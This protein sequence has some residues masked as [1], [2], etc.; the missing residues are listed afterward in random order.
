MLPSPLLLAVGTADTALTSCGRRGPQGRGGGAEGDGELQW[1]S[2]V[3]TTLTNPISPTQLVPSFIAL[4]G[5]LNQLFHHKHDGN[6]IK[7]MWGEPCHN[8]QS[9]HL[10]NLKVGHVF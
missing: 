6:H 7:H 5:L 2:V 1:E 10:F 8:L 9:N 4:I 3:L